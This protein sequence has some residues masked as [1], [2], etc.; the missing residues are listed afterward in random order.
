[1][2][3]CSQW[4]TRQELASEFNI[5]ISSVYSMMGTLSAR[6]FVISELTDTLRYRT[7]PAAIDGLVKYHDPFNL[8]AHHG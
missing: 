7:R 2:A 3:F 4:R 8:A 1:M 6:G 5:K